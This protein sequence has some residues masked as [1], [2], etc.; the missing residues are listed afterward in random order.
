[1][2]DK[3]KSNSKLV[4]PSK[5]IQIITDNEEYFRDKEHKIYVFVMKFQLKLN[6][7]C[8]NMK[9]VSNKS[10]KKKFTFIKLPKMYFSIIF[11]GDTYSCGTKLAQIV[12]TPLGVYENHWEVVGLGMV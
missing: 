9:T 5:K 1:M 7:K 10:I 3:E 8:L 2:T 4:I 6:F 11:V 12:G